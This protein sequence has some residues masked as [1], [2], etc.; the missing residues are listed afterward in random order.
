MIFRYSCKQQ[1][2]FSASSRGIGIVR[3]GA[4]FLLFAAVTN[5]AAPDL[6]PE[7]SVRAAAL[8]PILEILA[9]GGGA[10]RIATI[11][12]TVAG[13]RIKSGTVLLR[14]YDTANQGSSSLLEFV[15]QKS[16]YRVKVW[17]SDAEPSLRAYRTHMARAMCKAVKAVGAYRRIRLPVDLSYFENRKG[18]DVLIVKR[19]NPLL[20]KFT[21]SGRVVGIEELPSR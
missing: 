4:T 3:R 11:D 1:R 17:N 16:A 19:S 5:P 6:S 18:F 13:G 7:K 21:S 15:Y 10:Q 14:N 2:R 20:V 9:N 12:A 8:V